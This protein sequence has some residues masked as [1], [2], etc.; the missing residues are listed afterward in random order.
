MTLSLVRWGAVVEIPNEIKSGHVLYNCRSGVLL[1][2]MR[3]MLFEGWALIY[4]SR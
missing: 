1:A 2:R 4:F 3:I